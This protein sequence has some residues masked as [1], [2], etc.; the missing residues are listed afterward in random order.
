MSENN[1]ITDANKIPGFYTQIADD[2]KVK[3]QTGSVKN[4][5][6]YYLSAMKEVKTIDKTQLS[7]VHLHIK[8]KVYNNPGVFSSIVQSIIV[9]PES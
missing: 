7:K 5:L 6:C 1:E 8:S 3:Y 4:N 2:K 9:N